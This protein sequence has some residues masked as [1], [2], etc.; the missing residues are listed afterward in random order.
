MGLLPGSVLLA[1]YHEEN[2]ECGVQ[3]ITENKDRLQSHPGTLQSLET[4]HHLLVVPLVAFEHKPAGNPEIRSTAS[5]NR[6]N[7]GF[8]DVLGSAVRPPR[9]IW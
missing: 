8:Q 5:T 1:A 9:T 4:L 6:L 3:E 2:H 7:P